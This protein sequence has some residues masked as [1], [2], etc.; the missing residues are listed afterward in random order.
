[1]TALSTVAGI[2]PIAIG[3]GA[4]AESRRP[5]GVAVVGGMVTSTVL[6]LIVIPMV[7]VLFAGLQRRREGPSPSSGSVGSV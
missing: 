2:L 1:M 7:Y 4:G 5:M 6:T 3:F